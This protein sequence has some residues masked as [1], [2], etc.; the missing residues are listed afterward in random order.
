MSR[1]TGLPQREL[2]PSL[3]LA[4]ERTG[5]QHE[6]LIAYPN[7]ALLPPS[8]WREHFASAAR[9]IDILA[10]SAPFLFGKAGMTALLREKAG[11]GVAV[12][13]A[14]GD[15]RAIETEGFGET[16][17]P[18]AGVSALRLIEGVARESNVELRT[19]D[20]VLYD[21]LFRADERIAVSHHIH[22]L[23]ASQ[24]PVLLIQRTHASDQMF[25]GYVDAFE[26]VWSQAR[27]ASLV[28]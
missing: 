6:S 23:P 16:H 24:A 18:A 27:R 8:F 21:S 2:W 9:S 13:I 22:G 4:A 15:S 3:E 10:Y 20:T 26:K 25:D 11:A 17:T 1:L 14:L 7:R 28:R 5:T 12:R 19:H